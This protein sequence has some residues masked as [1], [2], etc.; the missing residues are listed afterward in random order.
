MLCLP[1]FLGASSAPSAAGEQRAEMDHRPEALVTFTW[2]GWSSGG[3]YENGKGH[4]V[5]PFPLLG[6]VLTLVICHREFPKGPGMALG[7][8]ESGPLQMKRSCFLRR[9]WAPP[10]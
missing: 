6:W 7:R 2:Q 5:L 9:T 8:S 4:L 1:S 10:A 3:L